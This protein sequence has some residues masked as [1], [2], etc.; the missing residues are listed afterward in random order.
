MRKKEQTKEKK[1][2]IINPLH[3]FLNYA[4]SARRTHYAIGVHI[5]VLVHAALWAYAE[6]QANARNTTQ[7]EIP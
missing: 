4:C 1:R 3:M 2:D 5:W 7:N 6:M